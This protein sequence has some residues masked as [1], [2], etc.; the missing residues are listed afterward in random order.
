VTLPGLAVVYETSVSNG[1]YTDH[2]A[3][4]ETSSLT[5]ANTGSSVYKF[6]ATLANG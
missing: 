4:L 6:K 3:H 5:L 1:I 2:T